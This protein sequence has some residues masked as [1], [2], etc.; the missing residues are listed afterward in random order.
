M[1]FMI[2]L[3]IEKEINRIIKIIIIKRKSTES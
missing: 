3:I 2:A 1:I